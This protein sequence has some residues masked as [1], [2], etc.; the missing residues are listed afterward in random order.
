M[1]VEEAFGVL[2]SLP[3]EWGASEEEVRA[4]E[5]ALGVRLPEPLRELMLCTGR[6]MHMRWLFA[7]GEIPPL[8]VLPKLQQAAS[9]I[10][11]DDPPPIRPTFP[12]VTLSVHQGYI[13]TFARAGH[14]DADTEVL[15]YQERRGF[16]H[17]SRSLRLMIAAAVRQASARV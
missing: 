17:S 7:D 14:F 1:T 6:G 5:F 12:F 4:V 15:L 3:E 13:I 11:L 16:E 9:E 8:A 10:L 2:R